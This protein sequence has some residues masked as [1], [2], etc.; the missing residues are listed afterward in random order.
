MTEIPLS[1]FR[2]LARPV[3][4]R[5]NPE[6]IDNPV[7]AEAYRRKADS[8]DLRKLF[9]DDRTPKAAGSVSADHRLWDNGPV[10]SWYRFGRTETPLPDGRVIYVGGEYEDFYDP[11]FCI[12]NDVVVAHPDGRVD[13]YAYPRDVFPPT[14]FHTATL[15]DDALILI[16]ALGYQDARRIGD[17]QVA[18][19]DLSTFRIDLVDAEGP[20]PGW[21]SDHQAERIAGA[22]ILVLGGKVM[23]AAPE[24]RGGYAL[25]PN[26]NLFAYDVDRCAWRTV[27]HGDMSI[28]PV[29]IDDYGRGRAPCVGAANP[30]RQGDPFK[31]AVAARGWTAARTRAHFGDP[32]PQPAPQTSRQSP[33]TRLE[34][35]VWTAVRPGAAEITTPAGDRLIIG[36]AVFQGGESAI[37]Y[38]T[39][40]DV[41]RFGA[42]GV[43]DVYSYPADVIPPLFEARAFQD[44]RDQILVIG[45]SKPALGGKPDPETLALTLDL[46]SMAFRRLDAVRCFPPPLLTQP[47]LRCDEDAVAFRAAKRTADEPDRS[48]RFDRRTRRFDPPPDG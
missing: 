4:G 47:L 33:P 43:V 23:T 42:D 31:A 46:K 32:A 39:Y 27:A 25:T 40:N 35:A 19:L 16:G 6:K 45:R 34:D 38:I 29:S 14:D 24:A 9:G 15:A 8:Y 10:W 44:G 21:L 7:W 18:R 11:E 1:R 30:E 37:D 12:Y 5:S 28:L 20:S 41:V 22:E 3:F 13:M 17:C 48:L 26:A 2:D 36:G